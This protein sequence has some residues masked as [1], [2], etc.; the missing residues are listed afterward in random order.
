MQIQVTDAP[1]LEQELNKLMVEYVTNSS[2]YQETILYK[3]AEAKGDTDKLTDAVFQHI[4]DQ[5]LAQTYQLY[6]QLSGKTKQHEFFQVVIK[7]ILKDNI[8]NM[9]KTQ[10]RL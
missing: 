6:T 7:G 1:T 8:Q 4:F 3:E 5:D 9:N 10:N 2:R